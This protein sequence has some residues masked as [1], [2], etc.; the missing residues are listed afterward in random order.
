MIIALK[1]KDKLGFINGKC[2]MPEQ[3]D[4]NYEEWQKTDNVVMSWILNTLSKELA[5]I[6][7]YATNAYELWEELKERFRDSNGPL[8]YQLMKEINNVSQANINLMIYYTKLKKLWDEYAYLEP[9]LV[10]DYGTAKLFADIEGKHKLMQF[11]MGLNETYDHIRNQILIMEPC[12][13]KAYPMILRI[14]KQREAQNEEAENSVMAAKV[15]ES[16][17]DRTWRTQ[18][19]KKDDRTCIYCKA[20]GYVKET[21]F[22]LNGYL[23]WFNKLKQKKAKGKGNVAA[24]VY[25]TPLNCDDNHI[26]NKAEWNMESLIQEMM[27]YMKNHSQGT[28]GSNDANCVN[29]TGFQRLS[30]NKSKITSTIPFELIH[31]DLWGPYSVISVSNARYVLTIVDDYTTTFLILTEFI[32]MINNHFHKSLKNLRSNKGTEFVNQDC[33]KWLKKKG[34]IH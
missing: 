5:E 12:V 15:S 6:F 32:A 31:V 2:K 16:N 10:C 34:I 33:S 21:C 7:L 8:M 9:I 29:Y 3:N 22:K 25:E 20:T 18:Y 14:E 4:K 27:K 26:Q 13:N 28:T 11:L 30:F 17:K 1:A 19:K 23:D 24:Q